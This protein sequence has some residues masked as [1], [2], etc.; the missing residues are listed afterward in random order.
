MN[1]GNAD[2]LYSFAYGATG[3]FKHSVNEKS[4]VH[5]IYTML[6]SGYVAGINS[7]R[8]SH[9]Q[10]DTMCLESSIDEETGEV[11]EPTGFMDHVIAQYWRPF[12][13]SMYH[14]FTAIG[15]C[16]YVVQVRSVEFKNTK[17]RVPI[18]VALEPLDFTVSASRNEK[19]EKEY[20][21]TSKT[22][23]SDENEI[24]VVESSRCGGI[25]TS[26]PEIVDSD[27][28]KVVH[29]WR[30][31]TQTQERIEH[32]RRGILNP[33]IWI[34]QHIPANQ[35]PREIEE[36]RRREIEDLLY[37]ESGVKKEAKLEY[38]EENRT[39]LLPMGYVISPNQPP[40]VPL[41]ALDIRN[42]MDEYYFQ[43]D[44]NFSMPQQNILKDVGGLH[45]RSESAVAETKSQKSV[46]LAEIIS[47][48]TRGLTHVYQKLYNDKTKN[49]SVSLSS[50]SFADYPTVID[51]HTRELIDTEVL[52]E[53]LVHLTGISNKRMR[54][55]GNPRVVIEDVVPG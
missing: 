23:D 11:V 9:I 33:Q 20:T 21:I 34:Q 44:L 55:G 32:A 52:K 26:N 8:K 47:D 19:Y 39:V 36:T 29:L 49:V 16:P 13:Q 1:K 42:E 46:A 25:N 2:D 54:L 38:N 51:L 41:A 53:E 14:H 12:A 43:V 24:Y 22:I 45:S 17:K 28:G 31:V 10:F 3:L 15:V 7:S 4:V 5:D 37:G 50:R 27:C 48:I 30:K 35:L 40:I 18:P 6:S